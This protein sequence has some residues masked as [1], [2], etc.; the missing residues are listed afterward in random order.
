MA[1]MTRTGDELSALNRRLAAKPAAHLKVE[2]LSIGY[3]TLRGRFRAVEDVA[4]EVPAGTNLGLVGES[5]CGKSTV[6]KAL[7]GLQPASA[8]VTGTALLD[9][10][11]V[12]GLDDHGLRDVR[13]N[14]IALITQSAMN[15]LDPVYCIGDQ[16]TEAIRAHEP[17]SRATAWARAEEMFALVGLPT[18]RLRE[19]PHQFSGG[20]RQ[21]AVIAM[22]L[23]LN[24]GL[25]LADEPTTAL[26]PIMQSQIM[27]RIR[28]I[29]AHMRRSMIL[30]T[31]DIAVVAETCEN[32]VVMYAGKVAESGPTTAVLD[33]PLHP[34][35]MGLQNAF[36][37]L[38]VPGQPRQPL[39]SIPGVVPNLLLPPPGC[40][41][42]SRCPFATDLCRNVVPPVVQMGAQ[43]AACHFTHRAEEFRAAAAQPETWRSLKGSA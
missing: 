9:G 23:A 2:G 25:L 20:M 19:F 38:P 31:H 42:A 40:R 12:L 6:V 14:R 17:V 24:A 39:I 5:G 30:V 15:A 27:A 29:H 41:F 8:H 13:W 32:T 28:G 3:S 43:S 35:T 18:A 26:D 22:A 16:I 37:R 21:R 33:R 34:Y 7:M 11:N 10:Q 4:F 36:P 1:T